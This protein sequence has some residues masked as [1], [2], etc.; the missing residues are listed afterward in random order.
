MASFK[1]KLVVYFL[2]LSLLPLAAAFWGFS[3]VAAR[4]ETRRVDARLQAGLRASLATYQEQLAA[5]DDAAAE[6]ARNPA[7]QRALLRRDRAALR[8]L[9]TGHP[10]LHVEAGNGFR[11]GRIDPTAATRQVAVVGDRGTR[12]AVIAAVPLDRRLVTQ[13]EGRSGLDADDHIILI[14]DRRV[15]AGPAGTL[16]VRLDELPGKTHTLTFSGT[17]YRAL[18]AETLTDLPSATIGVIS[19]QTRIDAANHAAMQRLLL[20]LLACL[21]LVAAV[22]YIEGRAIVRTLRRLVD[23]TRAI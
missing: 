16:G 9:L 4:S 15:V 1:V 18:V 5:A 14:E 10:N 20:G 6:L 7:F 3:T 19:P 23:A 22:A 8:R 11:V 13:L 21:L 17:R 2:L 12:G